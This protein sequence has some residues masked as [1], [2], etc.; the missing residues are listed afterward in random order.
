M[1]T[2]V[3]MVP[4]PM[5]RI[6]VVRCQH[7]ETDLASF[8]WKHYLRGNLTDGMMALN[9]KA[10]EVEESHEVVCPSPNRIPDDELIYFSTDTDF[11]F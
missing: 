4:N 7:C 8:P 2:W 6:S 11:H 10:L 3:E 9:N 5:E 1:T